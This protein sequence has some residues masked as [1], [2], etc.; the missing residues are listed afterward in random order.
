MGGSPESSGVQILRVPRV[1]PAAGRGPGPAGQTL[2]SDWVL[3]E[4]VAGTETGGS[5]GA[6]LEGP[7]REEFQA[8]GR[9]SS[10]WSEHANE[11]G[12]EGA[13]GTE[14]SGRPL[15]RRRGGSSGQRPHADFFARWLQR[16]PVQ[17]G[18]IQRSL[19]H[20]RFREAWSDTD[21]VLVF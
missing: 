5:R 8:E 15:G 16:P 20:R 13:P 14:P 11:P 1:G 21:F 10:E 18:P 6:G 4:M 7:G 3:R 19:T 17:S 2:S 9:S 12:N